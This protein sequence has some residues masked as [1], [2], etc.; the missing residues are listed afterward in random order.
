MFIDVLVAKLIEADHQNDLRTKTDLLN[1]LKKRKQ[2]SEILESF[3]LLNTYD[4]NYEYENVSNYLINNNN[5]ISS[6]VQ[7]I[8]QDLKCIQ[9]NC[10]LNRNSIYLLEDGSI[11]PQLPSHY[12]FDRAVANILKINPISVDKNNLIVPHH[13]NTIRI[14]LDIAVIKYKPSIL[15]IKS[16]EKLNIKKFDVNNLICFDMF[17]KMIENLPVFKVYK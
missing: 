4:N 11:T 7:N 13:S 8:T 14:Y 12:K 6:I 5:K 9:N 1:S 16:L 17:D 10:G 2:D 3:L 15:Q